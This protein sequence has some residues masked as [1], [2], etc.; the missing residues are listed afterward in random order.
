M[1][2]ESEISELIV[3]DFISVS[4]AIPITESPPT[5]GTQDTS[6]KTEHRLHA[7]ACMTL[8][9][10]GLLTHRA[11]WAA[12]RVLARGCGRLIHDL[13]STTQAARRQRRSAGPGVSPRLLIYLKA[14]A[15][16]RQEDN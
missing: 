13:R 15:T 2:F 9:H 3:A 10:S 4:A 6:A 8:L 1:P 14:A 16:V 12:S 11:P 7:Y 5:T